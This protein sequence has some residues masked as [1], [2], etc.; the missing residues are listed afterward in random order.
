MNSRHP[1]E[2]WQTCLNSVKAIVSPY[3]FA[4]YIESIEF[5]KFENDKLYLR[6]PSEYYQRYIEDNLIKHIR[7]ALIQ[8]L[9]KDPKIY[10]FIKQTESDFSLVPAAPD[11]PRRNQNVVVTTPTTPKNR[12]NQSVTRNFTVDPQLLPQFCYEYFIVGDGNMAAYKASKSIVADYPSQRAKPPLFV[13]GSTG[14]GK[15]H[16]IQSLGFEFRKLYPNKVVHYISVNQFTQ[17]FTDACTRKK[18]GEKEAIND[19][20]AYYDSINLLILDDIQELSSRFATQDFLLN[21]IENLQHTNGQLVVASSVSPASLT[22]F[23]ETLLT[24]L[25][26]G[27]VIQIQQLDK[28]K[29]A[30]ILRLQ[31]SLDSIEN[32]PDEVID[33]IAQNITTST[34]VLIGVY[35]SLVAR[36][37]FLQKEITLE[38]AQEIITHIVGE[39]LISPLTLDDIKNGVAKFYK[40]RVEELCENTRRANIVE[41]RQIAM[42]LAQQYTKSSLAAIGENL[43]KRSHSTVLHAVKAVNDRMYDKEFRERLEQ[44]KKE[45]NISE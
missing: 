34:R 2:I 36:T 15:T 13:F 37:T 35:L 10:Y 23:R 41:P 30:E 14:V 44:I 7:N 27:T 21:I 28:E 39:S 33:Y 22:G 6:V 25:K 45:L 16:L 8:I 4:T 42:F 17:R 31:A 26:S 40:L 18:R 11:Y 29:R 12:T 9:G 3:I 19:F 43:G 32:I 20:E 1:Q 5:V 24:R 38:L